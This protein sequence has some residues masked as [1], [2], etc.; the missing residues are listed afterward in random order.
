MQV[1][2]SHLVAIQCWNMRYIQK[3]PKIP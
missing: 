3:L 1:V 2:S